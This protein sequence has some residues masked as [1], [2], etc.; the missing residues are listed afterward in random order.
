MAIK[1]I[2]LCGLFAVA[3]G[4]T[5]PEDHYDGPN[6]E[7]Q[8]FEE[9]PLPLE[10]V[11][12]VRRARSPQRRFEGNFE[13]HSRHGNSASLGYSHPIGR[14]FEA[15][16]GVARNFKYNDNSGHVGLRYNF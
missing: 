16:G 14:N 12:L 5:L 6:Y 9:E 2:I 11:I 7:M 8:G 10:D 3:L 4:F 1:L 13:H 15:Y